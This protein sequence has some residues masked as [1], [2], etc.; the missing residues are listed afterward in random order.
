MTKRYGT[1]FGCCECEKGNR[2]LYPI[3]VG[4]KKIWMCVPCIEKHDMNLAEEERRQILKE[5]I[6]YYRLESGIP[7]IFEDVTF[8]DFRI[9]EIDNGFSDSEI[10]NIETT[11]EG[12][13]KFN[14]TI[15]GSDPQMIA[16]LGKVGTGKTL[17]SCICINSMINRLGKRA[18]FYH[19][20]NLTRKLMDN[21][22]YGEEIINITNNYLTVIDDISSVA[23]SE[24]T[25]KTMSDIIDALYIEGKSLI[26]TGNMSQKQLKEKFIGARGYDRIN[27][28]RYTGGGVVN[29]TWGSFRGLKV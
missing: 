9:P 7:K 21:V 5:R 24:F 17:L 27:E 1:D 19:A 25:R 26:I 29:F 13:L 8:D 15:L 14:E 10:R 2:T 16:L 22:S 6:D 3:E 11:K 20:G 28:S 12:L 4:D 18:C 23:E